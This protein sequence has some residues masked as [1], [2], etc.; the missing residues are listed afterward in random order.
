MNHVTFQHIFHLVERM[1]YLGLFGVLCLCGLG[2]PLPEDIPLVISGIM[3]Q[4]KHMDAAITILAGWFGIMAGDSILYLMGRRFGPDIVNVPV[5]GSHI[6]A[7]RL[8]RVE[9]WFDRWGVWVV[10]IGRM[11]AGIRGAVVVVAGAT[12]YNYVKFIIADGV[13]AVVSGGVFL[14]L[15]YAFGEHRDQ[16]WRIVHQIKGGMLIAAAV[17]AIGILCYVLWYLRKA[18]LEASRIAPAPIADAALPTEDRSPNISPV[19]DPRG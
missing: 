3:I 1:R 11:F 7:R 6:N 9:Q 14:Y 17:I 8:K 5:L 19:S 13:A 4:Q 18:R 15:G 10:A 2:L 12:R 16:L